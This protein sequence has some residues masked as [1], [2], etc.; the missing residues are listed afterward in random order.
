MKRRDPAPSVHAE[1]GFAAAPGGRG[2]A[3]ARLRRAA[4]EYLLRVGFRLN[5]GFSDREVGYAAVTE[6]ARALQRRGVRHA[7]LAVGDAALLSELACTSDV[8][9]TI[10]L[11]YVRLKCA[12]NG[13]ERVELLPNLSPE[14]TQRARAEVALDTA[15]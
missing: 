5:A 11:P 10:V 3:Y 1:V 4:S 12:L 7:A 2:V 14:L 8:P 15:A 9:D 6:I 13:F